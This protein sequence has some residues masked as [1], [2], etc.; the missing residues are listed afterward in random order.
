MYTLPLKTDLNT[1]NILLKLSKASSKLG[2]LNGVLKTLPNPNVLLNAIILGESKSSSEIENIFTTYDDLFKE[3][4][5]PTN[6]SSAK[7]VLRYREAINC[8]AKIVNEKGLIT[9][10]DIISLH[11]LVEPNKGDIRKLPGTVIRNSLTGETIYT[12]PQNEIEIRESLRSLENY[13]NRS[14]QYDPLID[15][16]VIHYYFESIHPFYD[17]NGRT[18]RIL[19]ILF[20]VLKGKLDLPIIYLSKYINEHKQE[21]Y[22]LL[23][24][25]QLD[26]SSIED[27]VIYILDAIEKMSI[28]TIEYIE[29]INQTIE[30]TKNIIKDKLPK[31][32]S[33]ELVEALFY[34]FYT[35]NEH[36]RE[37]LNISRNTASSY[38]KQLEEVGVLTKE[39]VGKEMIYKNQLMYNLVNEW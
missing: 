4:A 16:A 21:Y 31:I 12:P 27:F 22:R 8:G 29:K 39:K 25:I 24:E 15:M 28:F 23:Q 37:R 14:S 19:N 36:L 9:T 18:G 32:Y 11:R 3:M 6:N 30:E 7:E 5:S 38:L 20:L 1:V 13:I 17:G 26:E 10:N 2:E 34:E 35:K 33:F